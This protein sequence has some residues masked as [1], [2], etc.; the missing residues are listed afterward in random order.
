MHILLKKTYVLLLPL[1]ASMVFVTY[2]ANPA[3]PFT[4]QDNII[5]PNCLPAD[6][7]CYIKQDNQL[8]LNATATNLYATYATTS[9]TFFS[10]TLRA[11]S[12]FFTTATITN[13]LTVGG[14]TTLATASSSAL[15]ADTLYTNLLSLTTLSAQTL[16][17]S[18]SLIVSG[19]TTLATTTISDLTVTG[20][21]TLAH[22]NPSS[23]TTTNAFFTNATATTMTVENIS[24]S[25]Q[26]K[27]AYD[28]IRSASFLVDGVGNLSVSSTGGT[29]SLYQNNLRVCVTDGACPSLGYTMSSA[30]NLL[31]EKKVIAK[32]FNYLCDAGYVYVPGSTKYGTLP[33]FCTM[34]YEAKNVG[35]IPTSQ[36]S[37]PSWVSIDQNNS[38]KA[39]ESIG[40]GYHLISDQEWM[41]IADNIITT[42]IN[43]LNSAS[44]TL[45][46][47]T[48]HSD[49]V[50]ANALDS[51]SSATDPVVTG[52]NLMLPLGDTANAYSSGTC[53]LRGN[54]TSYASTSDDKGYYGTNDYFNLAY[55]AGGQNKS[56]LRTSVLSNGNVIWDIA[57]NVWEWTDAYVRSTSSKPMP[58]IEAWQ[59]Y[60]SVVDY[61]GL[62][63]IAPKIDTLNSSNG[64]GQYYS[65]MVDG[66]RGFIRGGAW[67]SGSLSG[68]FTLTLGDSPSYVDTIIGFR[69]S[70]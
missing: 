17:A 8:F 55:G 59:Q 31:V 7:N 34:K 5:N 22:F 51:L 45:Q 29:V 32:D 69:C 58:V 27:I 16:L 68:V 38:R 66:V 41:T 30:G 4:P 61:K 6:S 65:G 12:S 23:F 13:T 2:A 56:Q 35:G 26:M 20:T 70:R 25:P 15:T 10:Q 46:F 42:P 21:T 53:E 40:A 43:N 47:A 67:Y 28:D 54:T 11:F 14:H 44:T 1:C 37:G 52:C 48:G 19:T 62:G 60:T 39:C 24:S 18:T 33:G 9:D 63:Y 36:P 64:I 49:N 50:P 3:Q 57:G